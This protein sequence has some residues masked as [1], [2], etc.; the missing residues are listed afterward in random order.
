MVITPSIAL[1]SIRSN[2][3]AGTAPSALSS[4]CILAVVSADDDTR[5]NDEQ[6]VFQRLGVLRSVAQKILESA[7]SDKP[8][9]A[10][11]ARLAKE[12]L[13]SLDDESLNGLF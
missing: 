4:A 10:R 2:L 5:N 3:V 11:P 13:R 7:A 9:T 6:N 8:A 1:T 12:A